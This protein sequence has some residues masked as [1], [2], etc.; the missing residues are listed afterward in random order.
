M[1]VELFFNKFLL[2]F[3]QKVGM[4]FQK[5]LNE[6]FTLINSRFG[7]ITNRE[8]HRFGFAIPL[9]IYF[10]LYNMTPDNIFHL[11]IIYSIHHRI[12]D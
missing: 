12:S 11:L 4:H 10:G 7:V 8:L 5:T 3:N 2:L 1:V 9:L 6:L